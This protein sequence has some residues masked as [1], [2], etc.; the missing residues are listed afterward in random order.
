MRLW[1]PTDVMTTVGEEKILLRGFGKRSK[2][3]RRG[4]VSID[5]KFPES[6]D[7]QARGAYKEKERGRELTEQRCR[8][9]EWEALEPH[10]GGVSGQQHRSSEAWSEVW[11]TG[12]SGLGLYGIG[13]GQV[14][15]IS[16]SLPSGTWLKRKSGVGQCRE[17]TTCR[18]CA[19]LDLSLSL[20]QQ[21]GLQ[22]ED[23]L[24]RNDPHAE[25]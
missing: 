23:T 9:L 7:L 20:G 2:E 4:T 17:S 6:R 10:P 25:W 24:V 16:I 11:L 13:L 14:F 8:V 15:V 1:V 22:G 5:F 12:V 3:Q 18:T 19:C 21:G